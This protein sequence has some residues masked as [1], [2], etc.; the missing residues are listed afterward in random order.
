MNETMR[1][2]KEEIKRIEEDITREAK[3]L[4]VD[5]RAKRDDLQNRMD[6]VKQRIV[7]LEGELQSAGSTRQRLFTEIAGVDQE[8]TTANGQLQDWQRR[9]RE[10]QEAINMTQSGNKD[11]HA[12]FGNNIRKVLSD[13]QGQTWLGRTPIGPLGLYVDL[14]DFS[15]WGELMRTYIGGQMRSFAIQDA[16]DFKKLKDILSRHGK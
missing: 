9:I 14:D 1:E 13:I 6:A 7:E 3:K 11:P 2:Y 15:T 4:E 12:A 10:V 16:R 5:A 8:S